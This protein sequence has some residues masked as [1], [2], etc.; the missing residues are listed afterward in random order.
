MVESKIT[1]MIAVFDRTRRSYFP[2][3]TESSDPF[4]LDPSRLLDS[5]FLESMC[6]V[7]VVAMFRLK[8][9]VSLGTVCWA[10]R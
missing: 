10:N 4:F 8:H 9:E 6:S 1:I 2:I 7:N 3:K 5:G